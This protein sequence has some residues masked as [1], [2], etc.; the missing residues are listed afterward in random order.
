MSFSLSV[1]FGDLLSYIQK[2][3]DIY[4]MSTTLFPLKLFII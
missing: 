2:L 1:T 4:Y 3:L